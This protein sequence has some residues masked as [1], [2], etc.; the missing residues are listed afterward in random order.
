MNTKIY[1]KTVMIYLLFALLVSACGT[2]PDPLTREPVRAD[3]DD[4][5]A[6]AFGWES[7]EQMEI[8]S[9]S[10][11]VVSI[12]DSDVP[13]EIVIAVPE[14]F[15][16]G[17][18]GDKILNSMIERGAADIIGPGEAYAARMQ[19][20]LYAIQ[21]AMRDAPLTQR[22]I[23]PT[24]RYLAALLPRGNSW[25]IG[26]VDLKA[27]SMFTICQQ[28]Q[29]CGAF[30]NAQSASELAQA[31]KDNGWKMIAASQVP[32]SIRSYFLNHMSWLS[33]A[34]FVRLQGVTLQPIIAPIGAFMV[35]QSILLPDNIDWD[36]LP[37]Q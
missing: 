10:P 17:S 13:D 37:Q 1:T 31:M 20:S 19:T 28:L 7:W 22:F 24:S 14:T 36:N 12:S 11:M 35:P 6:A 18:F 27:K 32:S 4:F 33:R 8:G 16:A 23:D 26:F 21:E 9:N 15:F 29:N 3:F 25:Y 30:V 2:H 5:V 34:W